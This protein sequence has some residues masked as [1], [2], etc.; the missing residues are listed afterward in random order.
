MNPSFS[1]SGAIAIDQEPTVVL[2]HAATNET[3]SD[4]DSTAS[5][6]SYDAARDGLDGVDLDEIEVIRGSYQKIKSF[7]LP[8]KIHLA[9][10][11]AVCIICMLSTLLSDNM[12]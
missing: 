2:R 9:V 1:P 6:Y 7:G 11:V 10:G 4:T 3:S 5:G 8:L 12:V